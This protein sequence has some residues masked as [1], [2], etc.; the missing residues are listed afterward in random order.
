MKNLTVKNIKDLNEYKDIRYLFNDNIYKGIIDIRYLFNGNTFNED[1]YTE[2]IKSEFNKLSNNLVEAHTKDISYMV[3]YIINGG[4]FEEIPINLKDVR[5][6]FIVYSDNLPFGILSNSSY[7][8]LKKM[9]IVSSVT[10]DNFK[11][12]IKNNGK[13]T[14]SIKDA[15]TLRVFKKSFYN[16]F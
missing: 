10:F 15:F 1:Y 3:D 7:V 5:D 8:D 12:R 11:K 16:T 14:K 9:K 4:K 2:N 13:I 6:K